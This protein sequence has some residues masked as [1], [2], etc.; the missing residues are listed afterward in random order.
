LDK[1]HLLFNE[2]NNIMVWAR[3]DEFK[4]VETKDFAGFEEC[5]LNYQKT[6]H[7]PISQAERLKRI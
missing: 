3:K 1:Y 7:D 6:I 5:V 4:S 2:L